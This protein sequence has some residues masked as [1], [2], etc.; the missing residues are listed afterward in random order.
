MTKMYFTEI[1][2][3]LGDNAINLMKIAQMFYI[4]FRAQKLKTFKI[5][6]V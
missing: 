6:I 3:C 5:L 1:F 4:I 2:G